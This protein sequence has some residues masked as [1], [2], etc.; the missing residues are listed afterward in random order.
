MTYSN[1]LN[2]YF[3]FMYVHVYAA[4]MLPGICIYM[5]YIC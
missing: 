5:L 2:F 1:K 4:Y 3:T